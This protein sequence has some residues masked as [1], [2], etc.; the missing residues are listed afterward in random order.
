LGSATFHA[1]D[2][3]SPAKIYKHADLAAYESKKVQGNF[4]T[5][6]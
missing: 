2:N 4:H 1:E 6:Y 5:A 3:I